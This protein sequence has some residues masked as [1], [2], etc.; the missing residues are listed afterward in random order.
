MSSFNSL[1]QQDLD[2]D[3]IYMRYMGCVRNKILAYYILNTPI[4]VYYVKQ[5]ILSTTC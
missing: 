1:Y 4:F 3:M 2:S 5:N